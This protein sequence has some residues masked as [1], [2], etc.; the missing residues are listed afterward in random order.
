VIASNPPQK[1]V[2]HRADRGGSAVSQ[3]ALKCS[4]A[5]RSPRSEI[6]AGHANVSITSGYMHV[7]VDDN[8]AVGKL[9]PLL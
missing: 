3:P 6:A 2:R 8:A 1:V 9:F 5:G 4:V 7:A